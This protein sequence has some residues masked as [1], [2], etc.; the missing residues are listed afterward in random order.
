VLGQL[1]SQVESLKR[2]ARAARRY[3]EIS[4]EIRRQ[5]AL[6]LHLAWTG[7]QALVDSE[8]SNLRDV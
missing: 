7:A 5:D 6:L 1:N 8:E 4:D 3:K 2:Q